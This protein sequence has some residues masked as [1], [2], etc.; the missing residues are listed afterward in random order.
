MEENYVEKPKLRTYAA[1]KTVI[2]YRD[3]MSNNLFSYL[4]D[5][6][7]PAKIRHYVIE[8]ETGWYTPIYA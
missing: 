3:I 7:L 2:L 1:F 6:A 8:L 5:L 4:A